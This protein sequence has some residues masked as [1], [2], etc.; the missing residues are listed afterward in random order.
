MEL[1]IDIVAI[2]AA[3]MVIVLISRLLKMP[4]VVGL[5]LT[6]V[7]IGPHASG[8]VADV[9]EVEVL[10]EVGVILLL[11]TIGLEFS[12]KKLLTMKRMVLLG[13]TMQCGFTILIAAL[14]CRPLAGDFRTS[15]YIGFLLALSSTAVVL[16]LLQE[17]GEMNS[18]PGRISLSILIFQ[19]VAVVPLMLA[20]PL[21]AGQGGDPARSAGLLLTKGVGVFALVGAGAVWIVPR[22]LGA[23]ART[24]DREL[25]LLTIVVLCFAVA[26]LTYSIGLSLA[27]GAFLAG[28]VISESEY[29]HQA[30]ASVLP[31]KDLFTSFFFISIGMLLDLS[32]VLHGPHLVLLGLA[33]VLLVKLLAAAGAGLLLGLPLRTALLGGLILSQIGEFSFIMSKVGLDHGFLA[34]EGYQLFLAVTVLSMALTPL[35]FI[36]G[37]A[38]A[39]FLAGLRWLAPI[40]HGLYR[41]APDTKP[42]EHQELTDHLVIVGFGLGGRQVAQAARTWDIPYVVM[43]MN[44]DTVETEKAKGVPIFYGDAGQATILDHAR[45]KHA[46]V[47][48]VAVPDPVVTRRITRVVRDLA[49]DAEIIVRSKYFLDYEELLRQGASQVVVEEYESAIELFT[50]ALEHYYVDREEVERFTGEVR[51]TGYDMTRPLPKG[52]QNLCEFALPNLEFRRYTVEQGAPATDKS[53]EALELRKT[54]GLTVFAI[55]RGRDVNPSPGAKTRLEVGDVILAAAQPR[56]LQEAVALFAT[57]A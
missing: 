2:L 31:F 51:A 48:V 11:F 30:V 57:Q 32:Y 41:T 8:L 10:A 36:R 5:L 47:V 53:L 38:L 50:L 42:E 49:P 13:G 3:A 25:F 34:G 17:R 15:V 44:P 26:L 6:G 43:E 23:V 7:V 12:L 21:L 40:R 56:Q 54:H 14:V 46:R 29:S 4:S 33:A 37:P 39:D 52:A 45:V 24:R 1:L 35:F 28:L 27:L 55:R 22:L 19:D 18:P 9:H 16:K 20:V